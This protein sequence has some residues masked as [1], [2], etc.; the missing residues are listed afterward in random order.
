[1]I[2]IAEEDMHRTAIITPF[3]LYEYR[4]IPF[5]LKNGAQT[6]QRVM[7]QLL[8]DCDTFAKA[9]LDDILIFSTNDT[10]H[11][12]H[13]ATVKIDIQRSW[14]KSYSLPSA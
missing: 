8:R 9:Y 11:K 2:D 12:K 1:M 6:F 10:E 3:G 4:K 7:N 14:I 13:L 5:G